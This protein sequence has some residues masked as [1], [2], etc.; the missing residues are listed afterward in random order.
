MR[1]PILNRRLCVRTAR[2]L[3]KLVLHLIIAIRVIK[4]TIWNQ[5]DFLTAFRVI[6]HVQHARMQ[7]LIVLNAEPIEFKTQI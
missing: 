5:Q 1:V 7:L 2:I 3:A 4:E 6:I